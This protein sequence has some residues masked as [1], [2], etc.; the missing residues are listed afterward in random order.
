MEA[1]SASGRSRRLT[2]DRPPKRTPR[3]TQQTLVWRCDGCDEPIRDGAGFI[4][5]PWAELR[6]Y[7]SAEEA[8]DLEHRV[9]D[10]GWD[11]FTVAQLQSFPQRVRWRAFH[12]ACDPDWLAPGYWIGVARIRTTAEL[13]EWASHLA[14]K[15]WIFDTTWSDVLRG[16][17]EALRKAA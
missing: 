9:R 3:S 15:E 12:E 11:I 6:A 16:Q 10:D 8:W 13:L 5:I 4:G 7:K 14:E 2:S 17:A 1:E